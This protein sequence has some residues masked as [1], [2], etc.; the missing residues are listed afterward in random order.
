MI[1]GYKMFINLRIHLPRLRSSK[2][3]EYE[4]QNNIYLDH[5]QFLKI[6][7]ME[8]TQQCS[9]AKCK[10]VR[11][12]MKLGYISIWRILKMETTSLSLCVPF[13]SS[14]VAP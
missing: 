8:N 10:C 4:L 3:G 13:R 1:E 14:S 11:N 9:I 2:T 7:Q 12:L 6:N 5:F